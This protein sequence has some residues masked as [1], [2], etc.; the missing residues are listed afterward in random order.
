MAHDAR[1]NEQNIVDQ[2]IVIMNSDE[3]TEEAGVLFCQNL[4]GG[5][6]WRKTSYNGN[7]RKNFAGPGFSYDVIRDAF[8][9]P[10]PYASWLLDEATC[11]WVAPV[12]QPSEQGLWHWD[13]IT[14]TWVDLA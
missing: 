7:I 8:I 14:Q 3:P 1:L 4:F 6:T 11:R 2:V 12:Q 10:K 5:G 13:E 9:P